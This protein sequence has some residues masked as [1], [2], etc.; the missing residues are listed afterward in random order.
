MKIMAVIKLKTAV[1]EKPC[2]NFAVALKFI[3]ALGDEVISYELK[4]L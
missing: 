4:T 1:I 2:L 3:K